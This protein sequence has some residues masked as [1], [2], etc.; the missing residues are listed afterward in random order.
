MTIQKNR[1]KRLFC[2]LLCAVCFAAMLPCTVFAAGETQT[3]RVGFFAFDGY[4][5]QDEKGNRSGY[6]YDILQCIAGYAGLRYEYVGYEKNWSEMQDMLEQGEID[7]L[8]SAQKTPEREA[9]FDF[10]KNSIGISSAILTAKA[11]DA[12]YM[13]EDYNTWNGMRV[14]MI[15][16][17]SRND[18]F[19]EFAEEHG[20]AYT[21]VYYENTDKMMADLQAGGSIDTVLTSNLRHIENEWI[22]AQFASSPFYIM[23]QKGNTA[24]LDK[25]DD[26]IAQMDSYEPEFRTRLMNEYYAAD[27]G[28]DIAYSTEER[29]F[30]AANADTVFTAVLNP[31]RMPYSYRQEGRYAGVLYDIAEE[32]IK[33]SGLNIQFVEAENRADY[34]QIVNEGAADIRFDAD[35]NYN[36]AE[37]TGYWLTPAYL[38]VPIA[39]L[40]R[41]D[42]TAFRSAAVLAESDVSKNYSMVLGG[43]GITLTGYHSVSEAVNAVLSGKQDMALL[44]INTAAMAVRNDVTNQLASEELYG[45]HTAYSVAVSSEKSTILYSIMKKAAT[46]ISVSDINTILQSYA[47]DLEKPFSLI[48]YMYDYPLHVVLFVAAILLVMFLILYLC[49]LSGKRKRAEIQVEQEKRR[50]DLLNVALAAAERA[51][52]A[53]SQFLSRVSHEMRTPLNAIIGFIELSKDAD[54]KTISANLA[55]SDVAAKQLL[56]VINDVLDVSS[57]DAGKLK[58]AHSPFHFKHLISAITNIY[59]LQ[60]RQKNINYETKLLTAVDDW[61]IGDELRTNQILMNLLGNAVKFTE[62]GSISLTISQTDME[63]HKAVICFII[64]DTGCGMSTE[65]QER[66]FKPFEQESADTARRYGGSG[67]GLSIVKSLVSMM[68]GS[69]RVESEA[70]RG[71]T[72][73]VDI[74][75]NKNQTAARLP[76]I[77]NIEHLRI[78][79]V[80]DEAT[81]REYIGL[82]LKRIGV[83]YTCVENGQSALEELFEG[84]KANDAYSICILDWQMP[85]QDGVEITKMIRKNYGKDVLVIVVSAHDYQQTEESAKNA[86]ADM[87]LSK[88]LFQSSLFDLFLSLT[89]GRIVRDEP[90]EPAWDFSGKRVLLAEDNEL[91]RI[92][93]EAFLDKIDILCESTENGHL[94]VEKFLA[95]E[96]GYYDAIL[97]D[98][99]MPVMDGFAATRA[100]RESSHPEARTI[101]II[102]QTADAF[103]EDITKA[104][105]A[106]MNA[107]V[108]KPIKLDML[109][110]ALARAF[111]HSEHSKD[112]GLENRRRT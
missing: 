55:N 105:S 7:L 49:Q 42:T 62:H 103:N 65:M 32:I 110:R 15:R 21:V 26:A 90:A 60:C 61:L 50:N 14:G 73:T 75:Y 45:Y 34:W 94:A 18:R 83:R 23:V 40:F 88:P 80:D 46:S 2:T 36:Q 10:S 71:T 44:P 29:A 109:A 100:I 95:S 47:D 96:P 19:A 54:A 86:G 17:N 25:I 30:I 6:G 108:A 24:L 101:Q 99:Q 9:R 5:M 84:K 74:P 76:M 82:V 38:E 22:L 56:S 93:V 16:G 31:D 67:L 70:G 81:E 98:I 20:F 41:N 92:I 52:A 77:E 53:K 87:F 43:Q 27:S 3:V 85:E 104:L 72:F 11:G 102:A 79:A 1:L 69:I 97:M 48:G 57:I 89:N 35:Y 28:N 78:L 33:R 39:R 107:H 63:E 51:D 106:G 64:S 12:T 111:E 66:L 37:Q 59:E 13:T 8:T 68:D 4:H 58:I 112:L 91:N